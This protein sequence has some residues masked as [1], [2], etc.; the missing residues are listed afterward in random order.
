MSERV[1]EATDPSASRLPIDPDLRAMTD[2]HVVPFPVFE[3]VGDLGTLAR[4]GWSFGFDGKTSRVITVDAPYFERNR[5][6]LVVR[7]M[8]LDSGMHPLSGNDEMF[9]RTALRFA[10]TR[11]E[12]MGSSPS[13]SR[14]QEIIDRAGAIRKS[15]VLSKMQVDIDGKRVPGIRVGADGYFAVAVRTEELR[16]L[17]SGVDDL[18]PVQVQKRA[19]PV[20]YHPPRA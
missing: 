10:V 12:L 7:T 13:A 11:S 20:Y 8:P 3:A 15:A 1:R 9:A 4:G 6:V 19:Q 14:S 5:V 16:L 18:E 17:V 2:V